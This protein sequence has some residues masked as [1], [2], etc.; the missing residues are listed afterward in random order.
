MFG[1]SSR[2]D[3]LE[4]IVQANAESNRDL[5]AAI[6]DL[7]GTVVR[8]NREAVANLSE[9]AAF[10]GNREE[11]ISS[12]LGT[13]VKALKD[14]TNQSKANFKL[15]EEDSRGL[16]NLREIVQLSIEGKMEAALINRCSI[17]IQNEL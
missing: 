6:R 2:L 5:Q 1:R 10:L 4:R 12:M 3:R 13:A 11:F 16:Q 8:E 9:R 7:Q 17:G 14:I 15:V